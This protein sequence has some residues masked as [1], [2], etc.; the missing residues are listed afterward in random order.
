MRKEDIFH[1]I[2]FR[3]TAP[4]LYLGRDTKRSRHTWQ[5]W[6]LTREGKQPVLDNIQP[7]F[8]W[9]PGK[10][11]ED[12][13]QDPIIQQEEEPQ[14]NE[15]EN[16]I[17]REKENYI[18]DQ[19][20]IGDEE[21]EQDI[22][23][24]NDSVEE[25]DNQMSGIIDDLNESGYNNAHKDDSETKVSETNHTEMD[26]DTSHF[27]YTPQQQQIPNRENAGQGIARIETTFTGKRKMM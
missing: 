20:T 10:E 2:I 1:V 22:S 24:R 25:I 3:K 14:Q 9:L 4:H 11:I 26:E 16:Q 8:E 7:L 19:E 27:E 6:K 13:Q 23:E 17:E 18:T 15:I 12:Y 21:K 5:S